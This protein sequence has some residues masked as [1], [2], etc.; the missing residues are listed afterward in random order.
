VAAEDDQVAPQVAQDVCRCVRR[1]GGQEL[2]A[3]QQREEQVVLADLLAHLATDHTQLGT[4]L[5]P[6]LLTRA[7]R[8]Q[9]EIVQGDAPLE[10]QREQCVVY[11]LAEVGRTPPLV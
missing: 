5:L 11:G 7:D 10:E 9:V 2:R 4:G 3:G 8:A 1:E 6:A